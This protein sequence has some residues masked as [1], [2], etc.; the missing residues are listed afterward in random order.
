MQSTSRVVASN[1]CNS[2]EMEAE[3]LEAEARSLRGQLDH[4]IERF[5][6]DTILYE[7]VGASALVHEARRALDEECSALMSAYPEECLRRAVLMTFDDSLR[8]PIHLACDKNASLS[9][10]RCLLE[11]D[12]DK[13]SITVPDKW[14]DIPL[15]TAC[16][17]K[18]TEV[19]KLLVDSD[20]SQTSVFVKSDN[21]SLPLH[22]AVRY[23][24]P[25]AVVQILLEGG[26]SRKTLLE[27]DAYGQLPL[28]AACRNGASSD[29]VQLLLEYDQDKNT[30]LQEDN[31]GRLPVHLAVLHTAEGQL[32]VVRTL[33]QGMICHRMENRGL[34][35]W[36][37][38]ISSLLMSMQTHERNFTARDKLGMI[39]ETLETFR[40]RAFAL[41]LAVWKASCLRFD[42]RFLSV[43]ELLDEE[44]SAAL[45]PFDVCAYKVERRIKSGA[46]VIVRG[47]MSFLECEPV[48]ELYRKLKDY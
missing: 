1:T 37:N 24:A 33:L 8:L 20:V 35:L 40:E 21:G 32:E 11:A 22:S 19:V 36:K 10:L 25:A 28:H 15:H 9:V 17:R 16:S 44:A 23:G 18:Q 30:L 41:E 29:V 3:I 27:S 34:D 6:G 31:A 47:V 26:E 2:D 4:L 46:D 42:T 13:L 39:G 48:D 7:G 5:R 43:Q 14:G 38:D 45:A 12:T